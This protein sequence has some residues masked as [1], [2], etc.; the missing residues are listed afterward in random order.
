MADI[1]ISLISLVFFP[2]KFSLLSMSPLF[3]FVR[4]RSETI[5]LGAVK[6]HRVMP[7]G[8]PVPGV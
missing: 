4:W 2:A 1:R 5:L 3:I 6:P 8:E 7:I